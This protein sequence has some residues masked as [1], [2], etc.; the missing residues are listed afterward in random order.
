MFNE[1]Y[2]GFIIMRSLEHNKIDETL[3]KLEKKKGIHN[4]L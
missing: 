4:S 3:P 2:Q 1:I